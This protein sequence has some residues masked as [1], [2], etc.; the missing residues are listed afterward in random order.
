M[1]WHQSGFLFKETS[2]KSLMRIGSNAASYALLVAGALPIAPCTGL[3]VQI[4]EP[5]AAAL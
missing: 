5:Y 1:A 3:L 4:G 2:V